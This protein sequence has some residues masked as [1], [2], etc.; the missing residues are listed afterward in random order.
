MSAGYGVKTDQILCCTGSILKYF[1][2]GPN[3]LDSGL[4]CRDVHYSSNR[5]VLLRDGS[6]HLQQP[7]FVRLL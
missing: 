7:D 2:T 4:W 1:E 5:S 3:T 6:S